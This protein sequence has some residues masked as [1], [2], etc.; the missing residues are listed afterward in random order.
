MEIKRMSKRTITRVKDKKSAKTTQK[1]KKPIK[2][3]KALPPPV[4][5]KD[6][7]TQLKEQYKKAKK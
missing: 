3:K 4:L 5:G 7:F 6:S 1:G 2:L